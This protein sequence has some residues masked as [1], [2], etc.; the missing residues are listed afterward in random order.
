MSHPQSGSTSASGRKV[1]F[2]L[3]R[4]PADTLN[5]VY[6]EI[7]VLDRSGF[8]IEIYSILPC[9]YCPEEAKSFLSRTIAIAPISAVRLLTSVL[10]FFLRKPGTVLALLLK[11]PFENRVGFW[12]KFPR[13]VAHVLQGIHFAYLLRGRRDH[14]HAHF[15]YKAAT[16]AYCASRL[17]GT[18]F[19]FTAHGSDTI[20]PPSQYNLRTKVSG[21]SFIITIS[22][23]NKRT[24]LAACPGYPE[25]RIIVNRTGIVVED[26]AFSP[27]KIELDGPF[28]ILCVASLYPIKNH[29]CLIDACGHLA[30]KGRDFQVSL[31]GKD[32][33]GRQKVLEDRARDRAVLDRV[34][35]QGVADHRQIHEWLKKADLFVMTSHIEGIPVAI[36]EAMA[37][38]IPVLGPRV[39]GLPEL[40]THDETG[41]LADPRNPEDFA[42]LIERIMDDPRSIEKVLVPARR[43]IEAEFDMK[44]NARNV[45]RIFREMI[46]PQPCCRAKTE[47]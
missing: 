47:K 32:E 39:T 6:N 20:H 29:E 28:R 4:F 42:L 34:H 19:S 12:R 35:F 11:L 10:Y 33:K 24:I 26:F 3:E 7:E 23:F 13:T 38:G 1:V 45:A 18:T 15:A 9:V 43:K 21:A 5:F 44:T 22:E 2:I 14:V 8:E 31:V 46:P 16:A 30:A 25:N 37:S 27:R 17:N 40:V 41:W 36:M